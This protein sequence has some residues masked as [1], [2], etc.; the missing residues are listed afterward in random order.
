[1]APSCVKTL[2]QILRQALDLESARFVFVG[3]LNV[4][5]NVVVFYSLITLRVHYIA[6]SSAGIILGVLNGYFWNRYYTFRGANE[7]AASKQIAGTVAT[8]GV[9]TA[10][11]WALLYLQIDILHEPPMMA[12]AVNILVVTAVSYL[13]LRLSFLGKK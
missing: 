2:V 9:Q 11:S 4:V 3:A 12:Y 8:Y 5:I 13:G 7:R 10:V 6:A 1:M